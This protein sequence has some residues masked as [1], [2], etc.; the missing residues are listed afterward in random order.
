[1]DEIEDIITLPTDIKSTIESL[2]LSKDDLNITLAEQMIQNISSEYKIKFYR[3]YD[4]WF[5]N[6][7]G[8]IGIGI[9]DSS[10]TLSLLPSTI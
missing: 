9:Q 1:M 5:I 6:N 2:L 3:T 7:A 10:R 4:Y 8:S